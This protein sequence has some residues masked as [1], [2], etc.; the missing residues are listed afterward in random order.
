[1]AEKSREKLKEYGVGPIATQV[2]KA[3]KFYPAEECSQGCSE[4]SYQ[5][6]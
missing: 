2:L 6:P 4:S 5:A 3:R 1:M